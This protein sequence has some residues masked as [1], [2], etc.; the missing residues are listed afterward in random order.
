MRV[1]EGKVIKGVREVIKEVGEVRGAIRDLRERLRVSGG[2][3]VEM[4]LLRGMETPSGVNEGL[5]VIN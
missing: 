2:V 3:L 4:S 1:N 5:G